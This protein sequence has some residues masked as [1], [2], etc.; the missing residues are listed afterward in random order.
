MIVKRMKVL[1][2][3][4]VKCG[5]FLSNDKILQINYIRMNSSGIVRFKIKQIEITKITA[6]FI[7]VNCYEGG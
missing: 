6:K 2:S 4:C 5:V 1:L 7:P 3:K